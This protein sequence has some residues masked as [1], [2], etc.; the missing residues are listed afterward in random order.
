MPCM[1]IYPLDS[2]TSHRYHS[3]YTQSIHL[4]IL[5]LSNI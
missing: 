5:N 3:Y 2:L 1:M 4:S